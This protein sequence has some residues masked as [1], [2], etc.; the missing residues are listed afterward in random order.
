[1]STNYCCNRDEIHHF[2]ITGGGK[3]QEGTKHTHT[4]TEAKSSKNLVHLSAI[5]SN[6][7]AKFFLCHWATLECKRFTK[8]FTYTTAI[9]LRSYSNYLIFI[10]FQV[11]SSGYQQV[12]VV[13]CNILLQ[14]VTNFGRGDKDCIT[15]ISTIMR[16][17]QQFQIWHGG[18]KIIV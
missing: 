6:I 3:Y 15:I 17:G 2:L 11:K 10:F 8:S 14:S 9:F 18:V 4:P 16:L 13:V 7:F 1:M 12:I 5:L